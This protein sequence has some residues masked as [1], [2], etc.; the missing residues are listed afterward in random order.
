MYH[1]DPDG[2]SGNEDCG[3]MSA[4][5][6]MNA[7]G[8]YQIAPGDPV[9]SIGRPLF[10]RVVINL[11]GNKTFEIIARN[12]T[13]ATKYVK[14]MKLNGKVLKTPFFTHEALMKGGKLELM[15]SE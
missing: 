10:D 14:S 6:V 7:M 12:N 13:R 5:Y 1:A 9:Y 11:P 4:W 8:F 15:V 2:L 3:Q